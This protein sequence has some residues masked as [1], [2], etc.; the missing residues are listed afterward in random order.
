MLVARA[1]LR[2]PLAGGLT[3]IA[4]YAE[5]FGGV[6]LSATISL[7]AHV[8]WLPSPSGRFEVAAE[9]EVFAA[10]SVSELRHDLV[11]VALTSVEVDHPPVR[12]GVWLDVEGRSGLG[13]SGAVCTALVHAA[14]SAR[15]EAPSPAELGAW[16]ARLEVD[17]LAGASGYHDANIAARGGLR[18]L[19]YAGSHVTES[20]L[21]LSE[22]QR[23]AALGAF[24]LF[25]SPR[26]GSTHASLTKL[27]ARFDEALPVL[28]DIKALAYELVAALQAGDLARQAWCVG[29]Q[30]RLKQLLPGDFED[31]WVRALVARIKRVGASVQ[32]PGGKIGGFVLVCCPDGQADEVRAA[33]HELRE[34]P[35]EFTQAG[36]AVKRA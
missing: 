21:A 18:C 9:G 3:D 4:P 6:T 23:A 28:H 12:I 36:S 22:E 2:V 13:A 31:D 32:L 16:A 7:A 25:A 24:L 17:E 30:Q 35:L 11:R 34:V 15:G 1:P 33:L 29:E 20:P 19:E 10:D 5:R 26:R 8:T 14:L 27:V